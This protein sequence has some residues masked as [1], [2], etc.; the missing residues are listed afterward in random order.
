MGLRKKQYRTGHAEFTLIELLIV[1]SVIA[2]LTALLLPALNNARKKARSIACVSNLKNLTSGGISYTSDYADTALVQYYNTGISGN[3][4]AESL[5]RWHALVWTYAGGADRMFR[6]PSDETI[7]YQNYAPLSYALNAPT[8]WLDRD[9]ETMRKG[10][11]SGQKIGKLKNN[12]IYFSCA[13]NMPRTPF[14]QDGLLR[15]AGNVFSSS[16]FAF[17]Y[18]T[19]HNSG[20]MGFDSNRIP[21]YGFGHSMGSNFGRMDG[22]VISLPLHA[23]LGHIHSPAG[24][25]PWSI[26]RWCPDPGMLQ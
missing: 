24:T 9:A 21:L 22:S 25:K 7:R 4:E 17:G 6:C 3:A 18:L 5:L 20:F 16:N 23:Y 15:R 12:C 1:I 11:P 8:E 26:R 2:I 10:Y 14:W 19:S 13:V